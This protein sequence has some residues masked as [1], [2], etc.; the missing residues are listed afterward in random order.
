MTETSI[1]ARR[2]WRTRGTGCAEV[3]VSY[4]VY[5]SI[6]GEA[7]QDISICLPNWARGTVV[8]LELVLD[9]TENSCASA[10]TVMV[11]VDD[12]RIASDANCDADGYLVV[13]VQVPI[14]AG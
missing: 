14:E 8:D 5:R 10:S 7:D 2:P 4:P 9:T 13:T 12:V 6:P 11:D 3:G 1:G